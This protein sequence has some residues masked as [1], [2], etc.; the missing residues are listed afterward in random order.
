ME[1]FSKVR[2]D[3]RITPVAIG[4]ASCCLSMIFIL[5]IADENHSMPLSVIVQ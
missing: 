4:S 1:A 2:P 5:R 3:S